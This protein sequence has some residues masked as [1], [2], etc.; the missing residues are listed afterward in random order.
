MQHKS[1]KRENRFDNKQKI[2]K[3]ILL[4]KVFLKK[5]GIMPFAD[6]EHNLNK[7]FIADEI[8]KHFGQKEFDKFRNI[9]D[10]NDIYDYMCSKIFLTKLFYRGDYYRS[11]K[12]ANEL[13]DIAVPSASKILDVGGGTGLLA[14]YM[15]EIWKDSEITVADKFSNLGTQWAKDIGASR[16]FFKN[17]ILP[18]L[19]EVPDQYYDVI[20][21]SRVLGNM[22]E[23]NLPS[24]INTSW[25]Q[26]SVSPEGIRLFNELR[27]IANSLK[28]VMK[29]DGLIIEVESWSSDR[30]IIIG[31]A[32]EMEGLFIDLEKFYPDR[33]SRQHSVIAFSG[34]SQGT[35]VKDMPLALSTK[36]DEERP[37]TVFKQTAAESLKNFF[38]S[39]PPVMEFEFTLGEQSET[40]RT[41]IFEKDGLGLVYYKKSDG[42]RLAAIFSAADI[43]QHVK[44]NREY[45]NEIVSQGKLKIVQ[46][47]TVR[48]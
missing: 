38:Q 10:V 40:M 31:K 6:E 37:V 23:L 3:E 46:S 19:K 14:F 43:P 29:H 7:Q 8:G 26:Y 4:P 1:K 22:D 16:V 36:V 5:M 47:V 2:S 34:S 25:E 13:R 17:S 21:L 27:K 20:V 11:C 15:A 18:D 39:K 24:F 35:G 9:K 48:Y 30:V 41:E 33:L 44:K 32:F 42:G 45:E 12:V 28:R